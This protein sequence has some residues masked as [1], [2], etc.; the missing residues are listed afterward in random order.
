ML[1]P[2]GDQDLNLVSQEATL[3]QTKYAHKLNELLSDEQWVNPFDAI[4]ENCVT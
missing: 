4:A 3:Q 2:S 1:C